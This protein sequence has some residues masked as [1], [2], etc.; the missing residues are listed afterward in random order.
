MDRS[1][2]A[3][4]LLR[5]KD[6]FETSSAGIWKYAH[7]RITEEMIDWADIIFVMDEEQKKAV[8]ALEPEAVSKVRV[9]NIPDIYTRNDPELVQMLKTRLSEYLKVEWKET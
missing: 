3:E 2:T 8:T 6:G 5:G 9:L 1:P 7:R 4:S